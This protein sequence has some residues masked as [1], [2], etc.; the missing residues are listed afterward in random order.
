MGSDVNDEYADLLRRRSKEEYEQLI[1]QVKTAP[2]EYAS[3]GLFV[4][5]VERHLE[6]FEHLTSEE[7]YKREARQVVRESTRILGH[8]EKGNELQ[9]RFFGRQGVAVANEDKKLAGYFGHTGKGSVDKAFVGLA[10]RSLW[11]LVS[12]RQIENG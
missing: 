2:L 5:H 1:R 11:L 7:D 9:F 10:E 8:I 12:E 6:E 4:H 3:E